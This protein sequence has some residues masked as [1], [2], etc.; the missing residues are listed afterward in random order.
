MPS[1]GAGA[2]AGDRPPPQPL[3]AG[4]CDLRLWTDAR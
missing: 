2:G 4:S 3:T 1:A